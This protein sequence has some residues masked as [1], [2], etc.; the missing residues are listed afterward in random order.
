M[1]VEGTI[2][3]RAHSIGALVQLRVR[4]VK[5]GRCVIPI[6]AAA[7]AALAASTASA[8][9]MNFQIVRS[10]D[11]PAQTCVVASGEIVPG[12]VGEFSRLLK[13]TP[14]APGTLVV[15]NSPGGDLAAGLKLGVLI[16]RAGLDTR[17]QAIDARTQAWL[18]GAQCAS[19]CAYAFLGGAARTVPRDAS[20]GVHQF[21]AASGVNISLARGQ[22]LTAAILDYLDAVQVS[23]RLASEA[24]KADAHRVRW[25]KPD[26]L[27][28]LGVTRN[29]QKVALL[30]TW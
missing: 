27:S 17:V 6:L 9:P 1:P 10:P 3:G 28:S 5:L 8:A 23:P 24:L 19:A 4:V 13:S 25:L 20:Y 7:L 16:R 11:C 26:E 12:S 15:F 22:Q 14:V 18:P 2:R 29:P 21:R 30:G